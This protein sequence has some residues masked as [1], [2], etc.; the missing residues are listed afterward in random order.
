M[1]D[2][3]KGVNYLMDETIISEDCYKEAM[4]VLKDGNVRMSDIIKLSNILTGS[5]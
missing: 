1:S 5:N 4:D 3:V 2:L